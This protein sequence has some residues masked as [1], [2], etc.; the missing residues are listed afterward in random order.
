MS[1]A[2]INSPCQCRRIARLRLCVASNC[3]YQRFNSARVS[4]VVNLA[5]YA[6]YFAV[7]IRFYYLFKPVNRNLSLLAA[8]FS[9]LGCANDVLGLLDRAPCLEFWAC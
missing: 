4:E 5:A 1:V 3:I 6:F 7:T 8:L 2:L 9:L